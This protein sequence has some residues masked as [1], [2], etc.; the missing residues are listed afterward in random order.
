MDR[1]GILDGVGS[2]FRP[3][4]TA[5]RILCEPASSMGTGESRSLRIIVHNIG[6]S[7]LA[8]VLLCSPRPSY[9][10]GRPPPRSICGPQTCRARLTWPRPLL[11]S[12]LT[13]D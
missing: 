2:P 1:L 4:V 8:S 13:P 11:R 6:T 5:P 10:A 7:A 9:L 12:R 3:E